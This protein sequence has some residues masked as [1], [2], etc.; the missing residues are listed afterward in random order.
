[1]FA[2]PITSCGLRLDGESVRIAVGLRLGLNIYVP[3]FVVVVR[4]LRLEV[5]TALYTSAPLVPG[6]T[7]R[8]HALKDMVARALASAGN[9]A[10][11]ESNGLTRVDGKRPDDTV[12]STL[13]ASYMD[14]TTGST[15]DAV[16]LA[17]SRKSA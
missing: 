17:S 10:V 1:M 6:R 14:A 5:F 4:W 12:S 2:F 3:M 13:A 9:P 15:D 8:H 7:S 16:E 11:E